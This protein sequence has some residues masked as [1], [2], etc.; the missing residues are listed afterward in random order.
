MTLVPEGI[1]F[2]IPHLPASLLMSWVVWGIIAC[3]SLVAARARM[4]PRSVQ[5]AVEMCFE[6]IFHMADESIGPEAPRYYPLF[7]GLFVFIV[8][9][10]LIGLVPGFTSPTSDLNITVSL[11]LMVF[12][13]YNG[14]G[15]RKHGIGYLKHFLG[16]KLPWYMFPINILMFIIEMIGNFARPFSLA[17]R[18][19]CNIFSKE[20]LLALLAVILVKFFT[21]SSPVEKGLTVAPL[22]LRP[23]IVLLG[24]MIGV[25]QGLIFLVLSVAYV[26][27]AVQS[28]EHE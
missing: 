12:L 26:A 24:L 4:I 23:F 8:V 7:I 15:F 22:L 13:Y 11:A 28:E 3:V 14:Q 27:G 2:D 19:F 1:A 5:S 25:I 9:A 20:I 18:L 17:L 6:S 16:P 21:S 10:N